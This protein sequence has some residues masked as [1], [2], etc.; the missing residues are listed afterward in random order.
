MVDTRDI[1]PVLRVFPV[2]G[3]DG[4]K[5]RVRQ[6]L[7]GVDNP[8]S[9]P[10]YT[11]RC[12]FRALVPMDQAV[13]MLGENRAHNQHMYIGPAKHVITFPV[14]NQTLMNVVAFLRDSRDWPV[15]QGMTLP[16]TRAEL[17]DAF[18]NWGPTVRAITNLLPT[19]ID[20]WGI[21]DSYE[22][23]MPTY[24]RGRVCIAGDAAHAS[25]PHHGAGAGI[26][27]E[28]A[29]ALASL[30]EMIQSTMRNS[31][32]PKSKALSAGFEAFNAVRR[33]RTQ[34]FVDS[35]RHVCETYEWTNPETGSDPHRCF[36]DIKWRSDKIWFFDRE[37]MIGD[38]R[39][40]F[41]NALQA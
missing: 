15:E 30:M 33:E 28:D 39:R 11:H 37:A 13:A 25:S 5:S 24:A 18:W 6:L 35:S 7:A 32:V 1:R 40:E 34:W 41:E 12:A 3:C 31:Y 8:A 23:P 22:N 36:E 21:F 20:K 4:I 17:V 9:Y 14:A 19:Q 2:I 10:S 27:I 29:L 26:G 38:A 16:A